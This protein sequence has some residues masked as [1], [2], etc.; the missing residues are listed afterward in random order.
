MVI[1]L[2]EELLEL[3]NKP[4]D[5]EFAITLDNKLWLLQSR[6]LILKSS[7]QSEVDQKMVLAAISKN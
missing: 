1:E 7:V 6:K 2:L 4:I 5:C 3:F